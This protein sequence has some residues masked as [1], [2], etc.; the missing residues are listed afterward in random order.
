M[1]RLE[2]KELRSEFEA[3]FG[4]KLDD[5]SP[6]QMLWL[7]KFSKHV[8]G[9]C[10]SNAAL[11]SYLVRNFPGLNFKEEEREWKGRKYTAMVITSKNKPAESATEGADEEGGD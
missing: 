8:R 7:V 10:R 1:M 9:R 6:Q 5:V 4:I 3:A 11:R 2:G